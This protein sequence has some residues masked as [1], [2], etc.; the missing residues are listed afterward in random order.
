MKK[1]LMML[2][3]IRLMQ[4]INSV[5]HNSLLQEL[6]SPKIQSWFCKEAYKWSKSVN[7]VDDK[8]NQLG[9]V[10]ADFLNELPEDRR[11]SIEI[12]VVLNAEECRGILNQVSAISRIRSLLSSCDRTDACSM[13]VHASRYLAKPE[14]HWNDQPLWWNTDGHENF[15]LLLLE[16]VLYNGFNNLLSGTNPSNSPVRTDLCLICIPSFYMVDLTLPCVFTGKGRYS[17]WYFQ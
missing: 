13:V 15:D 6:L 11:S 9:Y 10:A 7:L 1:A 8:G 12:S 4:Q 5:S 3:K 17:Y 14:H 2:E 16:R